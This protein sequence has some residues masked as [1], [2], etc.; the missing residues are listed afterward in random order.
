MLDPERLALT[1]LLAARGSRLLVVLP[2]MR[3]EAD[4]SE[5]AMLL[6]HEFDTSVVASLRRTLH[7]EQYIPQLQAAL[8]AEYTG[9]MS[10]AW[11]GSE[12]GADILLGFREQ[13]LRVRRPA[14]GW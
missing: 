7:L 10:H 6:V 8:A 13:V 14:D 5:K 3:V 9:F 1:S 12:P 2:V 11:L 4:A